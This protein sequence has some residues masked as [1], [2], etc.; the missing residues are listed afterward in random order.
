MSKKIKHDFE[1][2]S[3]FECGFDPV[4]FSRIPLSINFFFITII[5]LI[6]DVELALLLPI[7]KIF[8]FSIKINWLITSFIIILI[9]LIGIYYEWHIGALN[10]VD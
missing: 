10:W 2:M 3:P 4:S 7:V 8:L 9:L 1:K 5:F 6:F